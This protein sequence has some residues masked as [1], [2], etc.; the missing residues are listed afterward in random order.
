[1]SW[2][3]QQVARGLQ[4]I[5]AEL[6]ILTREKFTD[7]GAKCCPLRTTPMAGCPLQPK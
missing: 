5:F 6:K 1:M 2:A 3:R 4:S 7:Y